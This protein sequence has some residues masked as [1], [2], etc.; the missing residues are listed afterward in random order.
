MNI[1][2][3]KKNVDQTW[4]DLENAVLNFNAS[5]MVKSLTTIDLTVR[6]MSTTHIGLLISIAVSCLDDDECYVNIGTWNGYSFFAGFLLN[7]SKQCVGNDNFSLFNGENSSSIIEKDKANRNF[8]DIRSFF[9]Y[10]FN[11]IKTHNSIF[12][13]Q[14]WKSFLKDFRFVTDKKIGFYFYDG[15]HDF[16]SQYEALKMAEP[17]F[18][19]K[20]LILVDDTNLEDVKNANSKFMSENLDFYKIIDIKTPCN[21]YPTW[22]N[23]IQVFARG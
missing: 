7:H 17:Y 8:G 21:R 22:W 12:K 15:A 18:S 13:E 14:D 9:Y 10:E 3:F 4:T 20:C 6:K 11:R 19:S 1:P 23:G 16:D 2:E 5:S